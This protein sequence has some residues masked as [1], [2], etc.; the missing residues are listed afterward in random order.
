MI[1][2][3]IFLALVLTFSF[4][5]IIKDFFRIDTLGAI[6]LGFAITAGLFF[7]LFQIR[8]NDIPLMPKN[9]DKSNNDDVPKILALLKNQK[10]ENVKLNQAQA[11]LLGKSAIKLFKA[12]EGYGVAEKIRVE[13]IEK[14]LADSNFAID[15]DKE[16]VLYV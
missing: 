4:A 15:Y 16:L 13:D 2:V 14:E 10:K 6:T 9:E 3:L 8:G 12:K 5:T 1:I 11:N 7:L